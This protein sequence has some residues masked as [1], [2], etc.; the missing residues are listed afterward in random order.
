VTFDRYR[1][2]CLVSTGGG[3]AVGCCA[4]GLRSY[5]CCAVLCC[6]V[7]CCE[8]STRTEVKYNC[9]YNVYMYIYYSTSP[10]KTD[11]PSLFVTNNT[12]VTT[13]L[14]RVTKISSVTLGRPCPL[15]ILC[16]CSCLACLPRACPRLLNSF[17]RLA[18]NT[19]TLVNWDIYRVLATN[20]S[21]YA[22]CTQQ[23]KL[24][25]FAALSFQYYLH[26]EIH[27]NNTLSPIQTSILTTFTPDQEPCLLPN[28]A[29]VLTLPH[30]L[31][32]IHGRV[33]EI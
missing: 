21:S 6:A 24:F 8:S 19:N 27:L 32:V 33:A 12:V 10:G 9:S 30:L 1:L 2:V 11:P 23:S 4:G 20:T 13:Y 5:F 17:L 25:T 16:C 31:Q 29:L 14:P 26:H 3:G 28:L 22:H 15:P 7:L 18:P